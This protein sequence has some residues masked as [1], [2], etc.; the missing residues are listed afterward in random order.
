[1]NA[2]TEIISLMDIN[3]KNLFKNYLQTKN[4][5]TDTKNTKLFKL[6]ETD[7]TNSKNNLYSST[8]N[9]A[10]HALRKRL[11]DSLVEFMAN[12]TFENTTTEANEIQKLLVVSQYFLEH[13]LTQTAFKCLAKAEV[14]AIKNEHFSLLNEIYSTQ[15]HYAH[16]S[17]TINLNSVIDKFKANKE[18]LLQEEQLNIGYALLRRELAEIHLK[19]KVLDFRALVIETM[20]ARGI[21]LDTVLTFKALYQILYI[22]NEYASINFNFTLVEPFVQKSVDFIKAKN[23]H[24]HNQLYYHIH[25]LYFMANFHFRTLRFA[26]SEVYLAQMHEQMQKQNKKYHSRFNISH[27][28]LAALNKNFLGN[29]GTAIHIAE[30]TLKVASKKADP[31]E[32][33]DLR[34]CLV[35]FL[36]QQTDRTSLKY[37]AQFTRTDS[38][39]EKKMGMLWAIR[40]S[41]LEIVMHTEFEHTDLALSRLKSFKRRYKKYLASVNENRVIKY[42]YLIEKYILK[43]EIATQPAFKDEI[44]EMINLDE[45][46]DVF[47]LS[48]LGWLLAKAEKKPVY[49]VTLRLINEPTTA[50][51]YVNYRSPSHSA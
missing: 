45:P 50:K 35:M 6:L 36:V 22:A 51:A 7:D 29:C 19:G 24:T 40:K 26:E 3:D 1:M 9:D 25:I 2:L 39:Y 46:K 4:T 32:V 17:P 14:K 18:R 33:N 12:R 13:K 16:L 27:N 44:M 21:S 8:T 42:A 47:I 31:A 23:E 34:I 37:A 38:W 11:Y 28:L 5:R 15:I 41:L 20:E 30:A 49:D 10:Y 48:F 43:P